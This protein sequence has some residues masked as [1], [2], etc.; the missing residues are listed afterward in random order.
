[1]QVKAEHQGVVNQATAIYAEA[2]GV[3]PAEAVKAMDAATLG[4]V[5][6][7]LRVMADVSPLADA[8]DEVLTAE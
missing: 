2:S 6:E 5:A 1:M 7:G 4:K 3:S 8:I